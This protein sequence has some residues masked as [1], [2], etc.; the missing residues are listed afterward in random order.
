[1]TTLEDDARAFGFNPSQVR[2]PDGKWISVGAAVSHAVHGK[3]TVT[4]THALGKVSVRF[5]KGG[6]KKVGGKELSPSGHDPRGGK[7]N[8][9]IIHKRHLTEDARD[10]A[11]EEAAHRRNKLRD[12]AE[13]AADTIKS[14]AGKEDDK[15][16]RRMD[17]RQRASDARHAEHP[18]ALDRH[19]E[20]HQARANASADRSL[21]AEYE[22]NTAAADKNGAILGVSYKS[23]GLDGKTEQQVAAMWKSGKLQKRGIKLDDLPEGVKKRI[24]SK[25]EDSIDDMRENG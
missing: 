5:D 24:R 12:A 20:R 22:R 8:E 19:A 2:G 25:S 13:R 1:M 10:A 4:G 15:S 23:I 18:N 11:D 6:L 14:V 17:A 21:K 3:G 16:G 9:D 7:I